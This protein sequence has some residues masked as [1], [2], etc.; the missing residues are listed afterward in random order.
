MDSSNESRIKLVLSRSTY[1]V[2]SSV[3]GTICV[4]TDQKLESL[5]I[6]VAGRSRL[7]SRWHDIGQI[8]KMY[9]TH[10][11]HDELPPWVEPFAEDCCFG[12]SSRNVVDE[13]QVEKENSDYAKNRRDS[14]SICFWST[15]VL[16]LWR[17]GRHEGGVPVVKD[18]P[19]NPLMVENREALQMHGS[20]WF[21]RANDF[22]DRVQDYDGD[23]EYDDESSISEYNSCSD[24]QEESKEDR[25][26]KNEEI[27]PDGASQRRPQYFTFRV[28]LPGDIAPTVNAVCCRYF[29]SVVL[30]VKTKGGKSIVLQAPFNVVASKKDWN[31]GEE[32][33]NKTQ[34]KISIGAI[35]ALAHERPDLIPLKLSYKAEPWSISVRR[36]HSGWDTTNTK[37]IELEEGGHKCGTLCIIG[38]GIMVPGDEISLQFVFSR[39]SCRLPCYQV[40]AC[41]QGEEFAIGVNGTRKKSRTFVFSSDSEKVYSETDSVSLGLSLPLT[42]PT[43]ILTDFVARTILCKVDVTVR[44]PGMK[45]YRFLTVQF[46]CRV[47]DSIPED[48]MIENGLST[49]VENKLL[50]IKWS[51]EGIDGFQKVVSSEVLSDLNM[52]SLNMLNRK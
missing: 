7:D 15:N 5:Q 18:R 3:V 43:S 40:S 21:K 22:V 45:S 24:R 49:E 9:G 46:P 11:C 29:Y 13:S 37:L 48:E 10:P 17:N 44:T 39:E 30:F 2:N 38:G 19:I 20:E 51:N 41:L 31:T 33:K 28:D 32:G 27:I 23:F 4:P 1:P 42:A 6:Y 50:Q 35:H 16:T 12:S 25:F 8:T 52:L 26:K 34:T 36:S 47:V 14:H